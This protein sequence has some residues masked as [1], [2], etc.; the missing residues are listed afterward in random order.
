MGVK[1]QEK[2]A[3]GGPSWARRDWPQPPNGEWAGALVSEAPAPDKAPAAPAAARA[4]T[5]EDVLRATRDS[6]R[7]LMMIRAYRMR[8]HLHANLDPL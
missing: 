8:G 6:V 3:L 1:P 2:A 5:G 4:L 7:A